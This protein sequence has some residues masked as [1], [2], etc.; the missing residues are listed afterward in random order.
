MSKKNQ[1][2]TPE[3]RQQFQLFIK[4]LVMFAILFATLGGVV[5]FFFHESVYHNIDQGL[6]GERNRILKKHASRCL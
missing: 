2:S 5:Y 3:K 6:Q 4:E 1:K